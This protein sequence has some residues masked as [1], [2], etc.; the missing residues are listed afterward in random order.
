MNPVYSEDIRLNA[1]GY[2]DLEYYESEAQRM[3]AAMTA[4]LLKRPLARLSKVSDKLQQLL[5]WPLL[6]G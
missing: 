5:H 2:P 1:D 6:H 3:S 4:S